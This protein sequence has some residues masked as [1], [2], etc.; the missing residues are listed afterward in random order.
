MTQAWGIENNKKDGSL[1]RIRILCLQRMLDASLAHIAI[2]K[3][4]SHLQNTVVYS[5]PEACY[6]P[7][8]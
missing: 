4:F 6:C 3:C 8:T 2:V 1:F 5:L 7:S